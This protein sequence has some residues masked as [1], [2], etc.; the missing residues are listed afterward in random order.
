MTEYSNAVLRDSKT[1]LK[2]PWDFVDIPRDSQ[3]FLM[4]SRVALHQMMRLGPNWKRG[5]NAE[6]GNDSIWSQSVGRG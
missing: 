5:Q 1:F 4:I 3:R 6:R 2:I